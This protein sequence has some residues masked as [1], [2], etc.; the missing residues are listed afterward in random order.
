M[1]RCYAYCRYVCI[2]CSQSS[3][4][5][6]AKGQPLTDAFI[7]KYA[8]PK[9]VDTPLMHI[10]R[11]QQG[12]YCCCVCVQRQPISH[13]GMSATNRKI[14]Y[15]QS[16]ARNRRH[17]IDTQSK[18]GVVTMLWSLLTI[19]AGNMSVMNNNDHIT[20]ELPYL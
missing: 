12:T 13:N 10:F 14:N 9:T 5:I 17:S 15:T 7:T 2:Q 18:N 8:S 20:G 6:A 16:K 11:I 19:T 3:I 4:I 1:Y